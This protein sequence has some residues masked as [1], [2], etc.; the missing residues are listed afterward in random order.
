MNDVF[1]LRFLDTDEDH[2]QFLKNK[3][4]QTFEA[5]MAEGYVFDNTNLN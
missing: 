4:S 3:I 2:K 1:L 5:Q